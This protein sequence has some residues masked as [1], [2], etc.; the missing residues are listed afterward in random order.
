MY[1][2]IYIYV[3]IYIWHFLIGVLIHGE[4]P[5][6]FKETPLGLYMGWSLVGPPEPSWPQA[7][8]GPPGPLWAGPL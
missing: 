3:Y 4:L 2:Y 1:I 8:V 7:L 5:G 6:A